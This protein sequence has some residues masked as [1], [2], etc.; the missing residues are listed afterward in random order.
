MPTRG[1][2]GTNNRRSLFSRSRSVKEYRDNARSP[3]VTTH[4]QTA[5][6]KNGGGS[7]AFSRIFARRGGARGQTKAE[8]VHAVVS[9]NDDAE[10]TAESFTES[11]ETET[12]SG[13][14]IRYDH[15]TVA[16]DVDSDIDAWESLAAAVP[17]TTQ[18]EAVNG[19]YW[20]VC[21]HL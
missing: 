3:G 7:T 2:Q 12:A 8:R 1:A 11:K 18:P 15:D 14:R 6:T 10:Y 21:C 9:D 13:R 5:P 17:G 20:G 16:V 4:S 19:R